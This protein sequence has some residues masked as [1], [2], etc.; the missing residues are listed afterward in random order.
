MKR[1]MKKC[2]LKLQIKFGNIS[3]ASTSLRELFLSNKKPLFSSKLTKMLKLTQL[4]VLMISL[5]N[6][7][8]VLLNKSTVMMLNSLT[9]L[10]AYKKKLLLLTVMT[11][12][13]LKKVPVEDKEEEVN[14]AETL[15]KVKQKKK[16]LILKKTIINK[17]LKTTERIR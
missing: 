13:T 10:N 17:L 3:R 1:T 6:T 16:N 2:T 4:T 11:K 5:L 9:M 8:N 14:L 12:L 7:L 15:K